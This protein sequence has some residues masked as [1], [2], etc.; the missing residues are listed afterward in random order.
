MYRAI[1]ITVLATFALVAGCDTSGDDGKPT[2]KPGFEFV[3]AALPDAQVGQSYLFSVQA[4]GG[5]VPFTFEWGTGFTPPAWISL[6]AQGALSGT[7]TT[8]ETLALLIRVRDDSTPAAVAE[9][10]FQL[11]VQPAA[12]TIDTQRIPAGLMGQPYTAAIAASGGVPPY[13]FSVTSGGTATGGGFALGLSQLTL[14]AS[15]QI[16]GTY[17]AGAEV[18]H[19]FD[20]QVQDSAASPAIAVASLD[21]WIVATPEITTTEL[22]RGMRNQPYGVQ[23]AS[24]SSVG[25]YPLIWSLGAASAALPAG[26]ALLPDGT[27]FGAPAA[28]GL[29]ELE[30]QCEPFTS[31]MVAISQRLD[32]VAYEGVG[33]VHALD[34]FDAGS[35]NNDFATATQMG[36]LSMAAP[37]VQAT[38]LSVSSNPGDPDRDLVDLF[39]FSTP[40][41]GEIEIEVFFS[42]FT[43][44]LKSA[45]YRDRGGA[46][47]DKLVDGVPAATGDDSVIRMAG[48]PAGTWFLAV[49]AVYKNAVWHANAYTFRIRFNDLTLP[50]ELVEHDAGSGAMNVALPVSMAGTT[51]TGASF[52]LIG[53]MLPQGVTLSATGALQGWALEQGLFDFTVQ[54]DTAGLTATRD[55]R[56]RVYDA[57]QGNFWRRAGDH[58]YFDSLRADGAGDFHEHYCEAMVV[59]PHPD[60]GAEGAIYLLGGRVGA[61]VDNVYVFHTTHQANVLRDHRLE[62]IGRPL[63]TERQYVGAA[64][65]QHSYGG[66]IYVVGGELYSATAPSSGAFCGL[67]ERMQVAD[68]AGSA[69]PAPGPWEVVAAMPGMLG[70]RLVQGW[71]E[72]GLAAADAAQDADDRLYVVG[73]RLSAETAPGSGSYMKEHSNAV[74]MY[75]APLG[76]AATGAWHIKSDVGVYTPR[77]FP[78]VGW[79]NGAI[80]MAG[81]RGISAT[82]DSIEMYQPDPVGDNAATGT[83]G[84][85]GFPALAQPIWYGAGAVHNGKLYIL[86]GWDSSPAPHATARLQRLDPVAGTLE[87]L[88]T[89]DMASGFHATVFHAG[90][91]W[92][93][94]GRD[95]FVPTPRF[96][97]YY[98]P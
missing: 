18:F 9:R 51:P 88:A 42:A 50:E 1:A 38:T 70:G 20:V 61:T 15:G 84:P 17:T 45:L 69:L 56:L 73:G 12:L 71:A 93:V 77:R 64:F 36:A 95:S 85:S 23:L 37:L 76:S 43:G 55:M 30:I 92:F 52:Q 22:P 8:P 87:L 7:P 58:R 34:G 96:S 74:L 14:D 72:F 28:A 44:K 10:Q 75:E 67:V 94:T 40:Y 19:R 98:T 82:L 26:L 33:Y 59:A 89:P 54:V 86:N 66:Y 25:A 6:S 4:D 16:T 39:A 80:Y 32:L 81:G 78:V 5:Q 11:V 27:L 68:G 21:L 46:A 65:L 63:S 47:Y 62:D 35:N 97:L 49:E 91:M 3:T 60:Y 79:I 24:N 29:Y 2:W 41:E 53:G 48:A 13:Q 57:G 31:P 90:R 83:T